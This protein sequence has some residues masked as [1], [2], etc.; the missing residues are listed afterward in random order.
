MP[1][2]DT[3]TFR[4]AYGLARYFAGFLISELRERAGLEREA[5]LML[6]GLDDSTLRR[7]ES[8]E[9]NPRLE[10][11]GKLINGLSLPNTGFIYPMLDNDHM[12]V[13]AK[14]ARLDQSI[15]MGDAAEAERILEELNALPL[16]GKGIGL[17]YQHSK[18]AH[19]LYLQGK[20]SDMILPL[21]EYGLAVTNNNNAARSGKDALILEEPELLHTKARV[22]ARSG[23]LDAAIEI[24]N[25]MTSN[26]KVT[27]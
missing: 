22:L 4:G 14:C 17:Q 12:A 24:L 2:V 5:L 9:Q 27:K 25:H 23:E 7:I 20:P 15:E 13:Y 10:T 18:R 16:F 3:L 6:S 26:C 19:I 21:I 11:L 1:V 8:G